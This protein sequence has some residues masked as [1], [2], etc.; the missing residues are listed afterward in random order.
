VGYTFAAS[1][2]GEDALSYFQARLGGSGWRNVVVEKGRVVAEKNV[3]GRR[4]FLEVA[5]ADPGAD[6]TVDLRFKPSQTC[7]FL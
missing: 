2:G 5:G 3:A 1:T 6:V 7:G 4:A